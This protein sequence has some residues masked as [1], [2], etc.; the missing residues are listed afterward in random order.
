[1]QSMSPNPQVPKPTKVISIIII[2][3]S[4]HR[5]LSASPSRCCRRSSRRPPPCWGRC[6]PG[7]CD[8]WAPGRPIY[9]ILFCQVSH[10]HLDV[11]TAGVGVNVEGAITPFLV[12]YLSLPLN[13][14]VSHRVTVHDEVPDLRREFDA[15]IS[16]PYESNNN[17]EIFIYGRA[18]I[19]LTWAGS[20]RHSLCLQDMASLDQ[21]WIMDIFLI[22]IR[23]SLNSRLP[24]IERL[25]WSGEWVVILPT[26]RG[27]SEMEI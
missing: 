19:R 5:K 23:W 7:G 13:H 9:T 21:I 10:H 4:S 25:E 24:E 8:Y 20:R 22:S 26:P 15:A 12:T 2:I 17:E 18:K 14:Q 3:I 11:V 6:Y 16:R 27:S 1:M